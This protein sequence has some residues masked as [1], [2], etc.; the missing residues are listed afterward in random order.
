M[1]QIIII[2]LTTLAC[3][4]IEAAQAKAA[5]KAAVGN[6]VADIFIDIIIAGVKSGTVTVEAA[7]KQ[8]TDMATATDNDKDTKTTAPIAQVTNTASEGGIIVSGAGNTIIFVA[9]DSVV[10]G[11]GKK[12]K[13]SKGNSADGEKKAKMTAEE[14]DAAMQSA[15]HAVAVWYPKDAKAGQAIYQIDK[16]DPVTFNYSE[17]KEISDTVVEAVKD[18]DGTVAS[19]NPFVIKTLGEGKGVFA[20]NSKGSKMLKAVKAL[21]D[22]MAANNSVEGSGNGSGQT[23]APKGAAKPPKSTLGK[24]AAQRQ[25]T[26]QQTAAGEEE[27]EVEEAP[28]QA[29]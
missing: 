4:S 27:L 14:S 25:A 13:G 8:L 28:A 16:Q 24:K 9:P 6:S 12:G 17:P 29:V 7:A 3:G 19:N 20:A 5:I 23:T 10:A 2:T 21:G 15:T 26:A 1:A 11:N 22:L 18:L